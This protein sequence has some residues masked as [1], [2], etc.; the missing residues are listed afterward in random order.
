MVCLLTHICVTRP[1]WVPGHSTQHVYNFCR[2]LIMNMTVT[3]KKKLFLNPVLH[4]QNESTHKYVIPADTWH[5]VIITS[6]L[7]QTTLRRFDVIMTSSSRHVST[8]MRQWAMS[9]VIGLDYGLS[10]IRR[11][12]IIWINGTLSVSSAYR[13][14]DTQEQIPVKSKSKFNDFPLRKCTWKCRLHNVGHLSR[15]QCVKGDTFTTV[16]TACL[17]WGLIPNLSGLVCV[18]SHFSSGSYS[19]VQ[20]PV[21]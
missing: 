5:D 18:Y 3:E 6:L 17:F 15:S 2:C 8:G 1:Q 19:N 9:L 10:P 14:M 11:Q 4:N 13:Y 12:T 16:I 7:C 21:N 20:L